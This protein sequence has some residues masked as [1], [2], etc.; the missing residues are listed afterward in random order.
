MLQL[1]PVPVK[2]LKIGDK[3]YHTHLRRCKTMKKFDFKDDYL[4][5]TYEEENRVDELK[6]NSTVLVLIDIHAGL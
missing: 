5:I 4:V 1:V 2:H 6:L 3:I